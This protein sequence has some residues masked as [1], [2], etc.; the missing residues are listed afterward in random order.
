MATR[1]VVKSS[2]V[3]P[4]RQDIVRIPRHANFVRKRL[5]SVTALE[6]GLVFDILIFERRLLISIMLR[7]TV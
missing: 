3:S 4:P 5:F 1:G 2:Q 6:R 7:C